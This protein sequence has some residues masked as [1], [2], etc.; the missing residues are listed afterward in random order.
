M[1]TINEKDLKADPLA[2]PAIPPGKSKILVGISNFFSGVFLPLLVP[3]YAF[4]TALWVTSLSM[5][6]ERLRLF[7]SALIFIITTIPPLVTILFLM[8]KGKVKDVSIN[9]PKDRPIPYLV[10]IVSYFVA[11]FFLREWPH[12]IPMFFMGAAVAAIIAS[13][14]TFRWKISAHATSM[15]GFT[16]LLIYIGIHNLETVMIIPWIAV[17][18]FCSGAVGSARIYLGRHTPAQVYAGWLLGL[19]MDYI[20]MCI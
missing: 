2:P 20:F 4:A 6:P 12:W 18:I 9:D 10:T 19:I 7:S 11:A 17:A 14:I 1:E 8:R 5:L 13:L 3:T 16:A 15:G